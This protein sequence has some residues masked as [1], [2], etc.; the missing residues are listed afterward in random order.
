MI[1]VDMTRMLLLNLGNEFVVLLRGGQDQRALPIT[2]GQFEAQAIAIKLNNMEVA[3]PLTHDLL[4]NSLDALGCSLLRVV[5]SDLRDDT[6][7]ARLMLRHASGTLE[8]D[9]RP[10]D[11]IALAL[12][13]GAPVLVEDA[14]MEQAGVLFTDESQREAET[15]AEAT[16]PGEPLSPLQQLQRRLEEAVAHER[17]EEAAELRDQIRKQST[18][19]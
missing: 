8:L 19:N 3:R 14:V 13:Y 11:A 5:I 9:A 15:A 7:Y 16:A 4:K 12:R 1:T 6:F 10:S 17:Y 2:I 18:S